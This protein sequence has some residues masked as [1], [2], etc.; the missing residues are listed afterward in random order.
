MPS[1]SYTKELNKTK[2]VYLNSLHVQ[3]DS[4][5]KSFPCRLQSLVSQRSSC[6]LSDSVKN[7]VA[8]LTTCQSLS[9]LYRWK[10]TPLGFPSHTWAKPWDFLRWVFTV[11][12]GSLAFLAF[13]FFSPIRVLVE[14]NPLPYFLT[15]EWWCSAESPTRNPS[16]QIQTGQ[17]CSWSDG[18]RRSG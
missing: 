1:L 2:H 18:A 8:F 9:C 16:T 6:F 5:L 3:S 7:S 4:L 15:S 10:K 17:W 13:P 12:K 11:F 14:F